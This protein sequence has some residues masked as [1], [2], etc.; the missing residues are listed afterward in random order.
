M[1]RSARY[2]VPLH[3]IKT[4]VADRHYRVFIIFLRGPSCPLVVKSFLFSIAI[5]NQSI[6]N[7]QSS[8]L[9]YN[10][11]TKPSVQGWKNARQIPQPEWLTG[12]DQKLNSDEKYAKIAQ[13]WEG[14]MCIVIEPAGRLTE[15]LYLL[16]RP[17]A[18]HLPQGG[19][20]AGPG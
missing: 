19:R 12:L 2:L 20:P 7:L 11:S 13:K 15:K 5:Y 8:I 9:G 1:P 10:H 18:R 3:G 4:N 6:L 16:P 14:D 17:V